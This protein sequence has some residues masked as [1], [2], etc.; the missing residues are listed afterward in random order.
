M[1]EDEKKIKQLLQK[2]QEGYTRRDADYIDKFMEIY[3]KKD[4]SLIIGTNQGEIFRGFERAKELFLGDWRGWGDV[5]YDLEASDIF[6][7]GESANVFMNGTVKLKLTTE[8]LNQTILEMTKKILEDK[9]KTDK[10]KI[11]DIMTYTA[12]SVI[13]QSKGEIFDAPLRV[14]LFLTKEDA[15]WVIYHMHFSFP[16]DYFLLLNVLPWERYDL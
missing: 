14:T 9:E 4:S 15:N 3:S 11:M 10:A 5:E 13:E 8:Y 6:I 7:S 2:L 12:L 16:C 1:T